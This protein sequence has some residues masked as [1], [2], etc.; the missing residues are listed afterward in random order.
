MSSLLA[1][2]VSQSRQIVR[3]GCARSERPVGPGRLVPLSDEDHQ[4][5]LRTV[6][7]IPDVVG[8]PLSP[9]GF[10]G[11]GSYFVP[12]FST[13]RATPLRHK[14]NTLPL[15]V[16]TL[17]NI[18]VCACLTAG[19]PLPAKALA[20][21]VF[22][23]QGEFLPPLLL[24]LSQLRGQKLSKPPLWG[25]FLSRWRHRIRAAGVDP[26]Y[27]VFPLFSRYESEA[28]SFRHRHCSDTI[29]LNESSTVKGHKNGGWYESGTTPKHYD[30][31]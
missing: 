25:R 4:T 14:G 22:A 9:S 13:P 26:P 24:R 3:H 23:G 16:A 10:V 20:R 12:C 29:N 1:A 28:H 30:L 11:G 21:S 7:M 2:G 19:S 27:T 8:H 5:R 18:R 15:Y 31:R 17:V 6:W